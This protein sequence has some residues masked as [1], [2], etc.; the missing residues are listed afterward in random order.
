[1]YIAMTP[2]IIHGKKEEKFLQTGEG[3]EPEL[4]NIKEN[5]IWSQE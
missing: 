3:P 5:Y 2:K 4:P 1:M